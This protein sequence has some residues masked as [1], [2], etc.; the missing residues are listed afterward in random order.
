MQHSLKLG[1]TNYYFKCVK[2]T[3]YFPLLKGLH[4]YCFYI[5]KQPIS[6]EPTFKNQALQSQEILNRHAVFVLEILKKSE[7]ILNILN[8]D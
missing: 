7:Q 6:D 4:N 5:F 3:W 1:G 2:S 8:I